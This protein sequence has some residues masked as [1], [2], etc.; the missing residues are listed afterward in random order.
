MM[1]VSKLAR[2]YLLK[3]S[4]SIVLHVYLSG[5][6]MYAVIITIV[7]ASLCRFCLIVVMNNSRESVLPFYS[8]PVVAYHTCP[9]EQ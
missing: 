9:I 7:D 1:V 6:F 5:Y 3:P 2:V 8:I 4:H